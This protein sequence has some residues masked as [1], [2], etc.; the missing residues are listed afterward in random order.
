[1]VNVL[2]P[3]PLC[4]ECVKTN[5]GLV[6]VSHPQV[7]ISAHGK[8][9]CVDRGIAGLM[10]HLW[11]VCDTFSCCEDD[12]GVAYVVVSEETRPA[13]V[14]FLTRLGLEPRIEGG[15][16]WFRVPEYPRLDDADDVARALYGPRQMLVTLR[17]DENGELQLE[18]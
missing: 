6:A 2:G 14:D 1:V 18:A 13:A 4:A 17:I 15:F 8:Q 10:V 3:H 9:S 11:E 12:G 5:G 16:V 7:H